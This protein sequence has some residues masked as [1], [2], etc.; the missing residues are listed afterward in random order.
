MVDKALPPVLLLA[1]DPRGARNAY[2]PILGRF[3]GLSGKRR[4][5]VGYV[6]AASGDD[7]RFVGFMRALLEAGGECD[8]ELAPLAGRKGSAAKAKA[9]LEASDLVF[10]GGGDVEEGMR[11]LSERDAVGLLSRL[12]GSGVPFFGVSAGAIMLSRKWVRWRDPDDEESAE[13]FDCLGFAEVYCDTHGEADRWAELKALL[14]LVG[15]GEV[16]HGIRTG[17][18]VEVG[19]GGALKVVAGKLDT[20][21]AGRA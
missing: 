19:Q 7:P 3:F 9:V 4:P 13:T 12:R 1:G 18:A 14:A 15:P 5:R 21:K 2:G 17:A 6:G 11:W 16:G 10:V 8:C 20:L